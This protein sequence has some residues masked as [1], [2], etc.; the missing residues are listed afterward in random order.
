MQSS[1]DASSLVI[2]RATPADAATLA[3]FA[4]AAFAD[5]F[6]ADNTPGD[7]AVY[8][9]GAF[10]EAKQREE[11]TDRSRVVLLAER[12]GALAGYAMLNDATA[13][14]GATSVALANAMEIARLYAGR[15]W[16]GTGVGA[17]L[18]QHCL[19]LAASRGREWIWLG[20]WE[21]NARAIAFYARWGFS[22]VGAQSFQLGADRQTDRIMA[23]RLA[24]RE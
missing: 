20:V 7:M 15:R 22:D 16:I 11:L 3:A 1:A 19:D 21:R 14:A 4:E 17:A 12:G 24:A 5:T 23:R 10:G 9:A 6:A 8:L 13:P 18:M 2:R